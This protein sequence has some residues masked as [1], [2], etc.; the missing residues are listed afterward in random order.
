MKKD[1]WYDLRLFRGLDASN[2]KKI[3]IIRGQ[4][5]RA[6]LDTHKELNVR[7]IKFVRR[8]H[9]KGMFKVNENEYVEGL[10]DD[11][12]ANNQGS[13]HSKFCRYEGALKETMPFGQGKLA[14]RNGVKLEGTLIGVRLVFERDSASHLFPP[15]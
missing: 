11:G 10:W 1:N 12:E 8:R 15:T 4:N 3:D 13:I 9:G 6:D 14:W 2:P 7:G 5:V